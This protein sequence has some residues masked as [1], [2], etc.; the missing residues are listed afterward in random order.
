MKRRVP[1]VVWLWAA[2]PIAIVITSRSTVGQSGGFGHQNKPENL[3][4]LFDELHRAI[5]VGD[6]KR[7][8]TITRSLLPDEIRIRK[9][10]RSDVSPEVVKQIVAWQRS[11]TAADEEATARLFS[12]DR[13]N[14][15]VNVH[16]A[17]TEEIARYEPGS[18][19]FAEF[20]GG[21]K[22]VAQ[23]ALRPGMT[24]YEVE[25]VKPGQPNGM[26]FHLFFWDGERWA[27][28][29]PVWRAIG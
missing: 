6:T 28:L 22:R 19:A 25:L 26:K 15:Q 7:A 8:G 17:T 20:P 11:I 23:Q 2:I 16:A 9:G 12:A 29:G 3:K 21:A 27:M 5:G 4:A 14:T 1:I 13:E 24:F 18:T 10:L